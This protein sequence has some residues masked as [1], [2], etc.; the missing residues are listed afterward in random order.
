MWYDTLYAR[1]LRYGILMSGTPAAQNR[2]R[3]VTP[4]TLQEGDFPGMLVGLL[5]VIVVLAL[6]V[7]VGPSAR[8]TGERSIIAVTLICLVLCL[9]VWA[10][11]TCCYGCDFRRPQ[12]TAATERSLR[13]LRA[14]H[15]Q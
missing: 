13:K 9:I 3:N 15:A 10:A 7:E 1:L 5:I 4:N 8:Q 11:F 6:A 12:V 14:Q 2:P